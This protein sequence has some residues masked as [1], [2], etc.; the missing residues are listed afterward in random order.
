MA[1]LTFLITEIGDRTVNIGSVLSYE[2][3]MDADVPCHGLRLYF[4]YCEPLPELYGIE[5]YHDGKRIFNGYVDTQREVQDGNGIICF[6]YARSSAC[7]LVDNQA[8]PYT[9]YRPCTK[10]LFLMNAD[11]YGFTYDLPNITC[12]SEYL[13]SGGK[14][15]YAAINDFVFG[16]TGKSIAVT[17]DNC[18]TIACGGAGRSINPNDLISARRVINRGDV[19]CAVDYKNGDGRDYINH[20]K[21]RYFENKRICS[22]KKQNLGDLP[23]WQKNCVLQNILASAAANYLYFEIKLVGIWQGEPGDVVTGG[24]NCFGDCGALSVASVR[25]TMNDDGLSTVL[26][27][28]KNMDL[29]EID[30][31][32][33]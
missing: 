24:F 27:L 32:A 29:E 23:E 9:Y 4:T 12:D 22:S 7:L 10:A 19:L 14:S 25:Y 2:L 21:S 8:K 6:V 13:V 18:I 11:K 33:E 17:A 15:C 30:Y 3:S 26:V 28:R 5:V 16:M 20:F 1:E 31:V